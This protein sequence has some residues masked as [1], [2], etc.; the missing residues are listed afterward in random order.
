MSIKIPIYEQQR[1]VGGV[2][3]QATASRLKIADP[4][5]EAMGNVGKGLGQIEDAVV[6]QKIGEARLLH[7]QQE[8]DAR[9]YAGK[10]LSDAH[11]QWQDNLQQ[12]QQSAQPGAPDFT[13]GVLKDF[14]DWSKSAIEQAPTDAAK[15]YL[16]QHLLSY[17][18]QLASQS[19]NFESQARIGWRSDEFSKSVD[20]WAVTVAKDPSKFNLALSALNETL[21]S[22][23]PLQQ[24]KLRDYMRKSLVQGAAA[25]Q[26]QAN[27]EGAYN[28]LTLST[29]PQDAGASRDK[30]GTLTAPTSGSG[31]RGIRNNNPGN[32]VKSDIPWDGKV[33]GSDPKFESFETPEAGIR[34]IGKNLIAYQDS[35]G[36]NT[37]SSIVSAWAPA[38]E[39]NT[40]AYIA[41]VSKVLG[42]KPG[43]P[44]NVK[45]PATMKKLVGAIITQENGAQPY[46]DSQIDTGIGAAL[47]TGKLPAPQN[48]SGI[49]PV[50]AASGSAD[51]K[52]GVPWIDAMNLQ[53]RLHY[54]QAADSEV[55]RRQQ[56]ARADLELK[57]RDQNAQALAGKPVSAP[58]TLPDYVRAY[59][60]VDGPRRYGEYVDNQQFGANVNQVAA[61][62]PAEQRA[63][64]TRNTPTPD[65]PGFAT[66]QRRY[67]LLNNAIATTNK[68]RLEAPLDFAAAYKLTTLNPIN[69]ADPQSIAKELASRSV[70]AAQNSNRWGAPFQVLTTPEADQLGTYLASLQPTDQA[71]FLGQL[72]Q[73]GGPA[74][75]RSISGQIKDKNETLS[76]A[77]MLASRNTQE[78]GFFGGVSPGR[79]VA[80]LYLEG[81][82][83]IAQKRAKI[84]QT[85]ETGI[86]ADIFKAIDGVYMTPQARDAAADASYAIYAK[87]KSDG[88]DS[89]EQAVNVATGGIMDF[90]GAKI[91]KPYGWKDSQFRDAVIASGPQQVNAAGKEFVAGDKK[92]SAA[93]LAK[94]LL[95]AKL[96]TFGDGTYMIR[97]GSDVVRLSDGRP[98][99]LKVGQ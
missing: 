68:Q 38:S 15:R 57:E 79:N 28:L 81:K 25:G 83:A 33:D 70:I 37:I 43:D 87:Y 41:N 4:V 74:A 71:R 9:A 97:A 44:I 19:L 6:L 52:I 92:V 96:Q 36:R 39:N 88:R 67:E 82:D 93:D 24:E 13:P 12:R 10:A 51:A 1:E 26:V 85:A 48:A 64:L 66:D 94:S 91:A 61:M 40:A 35:H 18:T 21:P 11:V 98:F 76:I 84:D 56:I 65:A 62:S 77:G 32:I 2:G 45:D 46:T 27:P 90:N 86:K 75:L 34:A 95:G 3:P 23:G 17:R 31:N 58:L 78:V 14:D 42:V 47:G 53:E 7:Q 60:Q 80:Q 29:L 22:V 55:R 49:V 73:A 8:E 30:T 5:G 16:G 20:N 69:F 63:M 59:G 89:W 54:L 50:Q 72:Y 99:V